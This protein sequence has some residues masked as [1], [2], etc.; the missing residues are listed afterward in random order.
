MKRVTAALWLCLSCQPASD[1]TG[2][3]DGGANPQTTD[4]CSG[5][6]FIEADSG[7]MIFAKRFGAAGRDRA[8]GIAVDASGNAVMAG[9]FA[10]MVDFGGTT[11]TSG[12]GFSSFVA[13]YDAAGSLLWAKRAAVSGEPSIAHVKVDPSGGVIVCGL[14]TGTVDFGGGAIAASSGSSGD[15]FVA[16]FASDGSYA[17]ARTYG[18][19]A[20][21]SAAGLAVDGDSVV[22][23]GA[24]DGS[25]TFGTQTLTTQG[26]QDIYAFS[27]ALD[28]TPRWARSYGGVS[29]DRAVGVALQNGEVWI[30]NLFAGTVDFGGGPVASSGQLDLILLTLN[31]DGQLR[32]TR[33][34]GGA[35]SDEPSRAPAVDRCGNAT[36]TGYFQNQ[37]DLGGG[38]LIGTTPITGFIARYAG[39]GSHVFSRTLNG[40]G[41]LGNNT[42]LGPDNSIWIL[43][44]YR[45][46]LTLGSIALQG[47]GSEDLFVTRIKPDG[48]HLWARG[49]GG[50]GEDSADSIAVGADGSAY[51]AGQFVNTVDFGG[52]ALTSAGQD[53]IFLI[54]LAP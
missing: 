13:R 36:I 16:R 51:I 48:T 42:A 15:L 1:M 37:T 33:R 44:S 27:H 29:T 21:K 23:V 32:S 34:A 2:M 50:S 7:R 41:A 8:V 28:G 4:P 6:P 14:F 54:K 38:P 20:S 45:S 11:L 46:A 49:F 39:D 30:N 3:P 25:L 12:S 10:N 22:M 5:S 40:V 43:G 26:A 24:F 53:D 18:G 35:G 52:T 9:R 19:T 31:K 47:A 17:W